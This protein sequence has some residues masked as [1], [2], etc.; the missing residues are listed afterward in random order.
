[1]ALVYLATNLVNG[2]RYV[3][4]T[5]KTLE[6]RA[7]NHIYRAMKVGA[8]QAISMAIRKYG[9]E[10]FRFRALKIT[11]TIDEA[12]SDEIRLI[13]AL[14]PEYNMTLGGDGIWGFK[15]SQSSIEKMSAHR[16]GKPWAWMTGPRRD[17]ISLRI[18]AAKLKPVICVSDG[19]EYPSVKD[20][21]AAY[22]LR[23]SDI[24]T[25]CRGRQYSAAGL[26]FR[27][28]HGAAP[29]AFKRGEAKSLIFMCVETG[30]VARGIYRAAAAFG[31]SHNWLR[32]AA[33]TGMLVAKTGHHYRFVPKGA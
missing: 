14:R 19:V 1:M 24:T 32:K 10:M 5:A 23:P 18:S 29:V 16:R 17:E 4:I 11:G 7:Y 2:K 20:A 26:R 25:V 31:L 12:K 3:G 28:A 6:Q 33:A 8:T 9:P 13:A 21:A 22:G 30:Q 27:Y 15:F